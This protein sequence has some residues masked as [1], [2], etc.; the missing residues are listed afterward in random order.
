MKRRIFLAMAATVFILAGCGDSGEKSTHAIE[1]QTIE[2]TDGAQQKDASADGAGSESNANAQEN[3]DAKE[4]ESAQDNADAKDYADQIKTEIAEIAKGSES[5]SK[6][7]VSVN[8][9]YS[10]YEEIIGNA[11]NQTEMNLLSQWGSWVWEEETLSLLNR[12]KEK[13]PDSYKEIVSEY[14]NWESHV[15]FMANQM[16][17]VFD[18]GSLHPTVYSYNRAM[19]YKRKAYSLASTL[20]DV[21]KEV[22]FNFPDS[23]R[24]GFYG[25]YAGSS[26]LIITEG[27]GNYSYDILI[28]IDDEKELRGRGEVEDAPDSDTYLLFTSDDG[29]VEGYVSHSSLE[30]SFYVTKTDNAVVGPE[31][32]YTFT[33]QY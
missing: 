13:A 17:Y 9:L 6:E 25:D 19:R 22:D 24:C 5:L 33:F 12:I 8:E 4:N 28:H 1:S 3:A 21:T 20:A 15:P 29:T 2:T 30:A 32:A 26:Y 31:G 11:Q 16:S 7:L 27:A 10:K 23:S 14:E 18:G